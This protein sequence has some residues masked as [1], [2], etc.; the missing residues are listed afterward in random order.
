[1]DP[2]RRAQMTFI[3]LLGKGTKKKKQQKKTGKSSNPPQFWGDRHVTAAASQ[4]QPP[5]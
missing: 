4:A 1:M 3:C 5:Y 2:S